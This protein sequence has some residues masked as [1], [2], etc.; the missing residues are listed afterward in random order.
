MSV[1]VLGGTSWLGGEVARTALAAGHEVTCLARGES[2]PVPEGASLLRTDRSQPD[3]YAVLPASARWDL[4]VEVTWQPGFARGALRALA[5][6]AAQWVYI[7]S[8]S[9]YADQS[10][11][12]ADESA[13][14][15][16]PLEADTAGRAQYGEAKVACEAACTAYRAGEV[17]VARSGL[18]A[19]YGDRSDRFGYWPGRFALAVE[20]GAPVLVPQ[21]QERPAQL[22]DVRDLAGWVVN[23]G[24]AGVT[25][26]FNASGPVST[27]G[28]VLA[29]SRQ[30]SGFAGATVSAGDEQLVA[31]QVEEYMGPRSLPLWMCDPSFAGFSSRDVAK[32]VSAGLTHRPLLDTAQDALR[33]ERE[34][35]LE[36]LDRSAGLSR[37]EE[38]EI[39]AALPG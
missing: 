15:L 14:L 21:G 12:G 30:V 20:D 8:C 33:W 19:G 10:R 25:G 1:L 36:R 37:A 9:V 6:R 32:S 2:G 11:A 38:L 22:I 13:P 27:V 34:L 31:A 17:L 4:V 39:I 24:L 5:E 26:S 28:E 3:G 7:S 29:A 18:I 23:A 35:G 16:S